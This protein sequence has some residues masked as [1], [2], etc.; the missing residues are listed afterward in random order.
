MCMPL[1]HESEPHCTVEPIFC[2]VLQLV[3][4]R[5]FRHGRG[6][7]IKW[8]AARS[9]AARRVTKARS[10]HDAGHCRGPDCCGRIHER[11]AQPAKGDCAPPIYLA[12]TRMHFCWQSRASASVLCL[13]TH[14]CS[15]MGNVDL[16]LLLDARGVCLVPWLRFASLC[17]RM[18]SDH[19]TSQLTHAGLPDD[20]G[21]Y[22]CAC[23]RCFCDTGSIRLGSFIS[24]PRP[25]KIAAIMQHVKLE[26]RVLCHRHKTCLR[27]VFCIYIECFNCPQGGNGTPQ[28]CFGVLLPILSLESA[29]CTTDL[30]VVYTQLAMSMKHMF[31]RG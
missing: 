10:A 30:D 31:R 8:S 26:A 3:R 6:W 11:Q 12:C 14:V 13:L 27:P 18:L 5:A 19:I 28:E 17:R 24:T 20:Y 4:W 16:Q 25:R 2:N 23:G 21:H 22:C 7:S 9:K 1:T 15:G 29:D